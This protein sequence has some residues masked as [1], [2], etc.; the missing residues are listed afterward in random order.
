M[1]ALTA[2]I[3]LSFISAKNIFCYKCSK[4]A[5]LIRDF[6]GVERQMLSANGKGPKFDGPVSLKTNL[7][8]FQQP[9]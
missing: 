4:K 9:L 2:F 1:K 3:A 8:A 5:N 6:H 7:T